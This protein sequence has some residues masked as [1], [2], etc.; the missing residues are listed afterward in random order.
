MKDAQISRLHRL[1]VFVAKDYF[2]KV[3]VWLK[4]GSALLED[5]YVSICLEMLFSGRGRN[6]LAS[7]AID[8]TFPACVFFDDFHGLLLVIDAGRDKRPLAIL[9]FEIKTPT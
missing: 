1:F 2:S 3:G 4:N 6:A 8:F 7:A 5:A 9:A